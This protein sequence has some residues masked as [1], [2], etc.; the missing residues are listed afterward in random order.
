MNTFR[1]MS[2]RISFTV[3]LNFKNCSILDLSVDAI[4]CPTST[5]GLMSQG[6]SLLIKETGGDVIET[7]ILDIAPLAIGAAAVTTSGS[8]SNAAHVIHCPNRMEDSNL[9]RIEHIRLSVRAALVASN[10]YKYDTLAIPVPGPCAKL[11]TMKEIARAMID[12]IRN[13]RETPPSVVYLVDP[14]IEMVRAWEGYAFPQ[15]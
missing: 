15:K 5:Q 6:P 9:A 8:L 12:E 14:D 13:F 4:C 2:N 10:F 7:E 3:E 11:I 1:A